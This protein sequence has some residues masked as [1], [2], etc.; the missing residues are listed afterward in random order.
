MSRLQSEKFF[1]DNEISGIK[2]T[3][4]EL[5]EKVKLGFALLHPDE[6]S[7]S[8]Q[9]KLYDD[10]VMDFTS[11]TKESIAKKRIIFEKFFVCDFRFEKQQNLHITLNRNN[12]P[13][14]FNTT[15]GN[16]IGSI[17]GTFTK[18]FD[19]DQCLV[20]KVEKLGKDE[21][22][23]NIRINLKN[24]T[25]PNFFLNNK[26]YYLITSRNN[27]IYKSAEITNFGFFAPIQIPTCLLQPSYTISFYN[28]YNKPIFTFNRTTQDVKTKKRLQLKIH[29][30][31]DKYLIL[32]DN[33]EITQKF[34]FLDYLKSGI[35]IALSIGI[36]FSTSHIL[37]SNY[38]TLHSIQGGNDYERAIISCANILGYYDYDQL[39]PVFGFGAIIN[40]SYSN[41]PSTCFNLNFAENP[42]IYTISNVLKAYRDCIQQNMLTFSGHSQFT[43]LIRKVI[44]RI[45]Q[46]DIFEYHILLILTDGLIDDLQQTIDILV[47]ASLLPLSV[48]IV[49]IGNGDFKNMEILDGDQIPLTSSSGKKRMRDLVQFVPFSKYQNN[50]EKLSMEVLAEIPRQIVEYY[51]FKN[52]NPNQIENLIKSGQ[53]I[54]NYN[55]QNNYQYNQNFNNTNSNMLNPGY[56]INPNEGSHLRRVYTNPVNINYQNPNLFSNMNNNPNIDSGFK[57]SFTQGNDIYYQEK[58]DKQD[59]QIININN[60][61]SYTNNIYINNSQKSDKMSK[62]VSSTSNSHNS[63]HNAPLD[64]PKK[65]VIDLTNIP[66]SETVTLTHINMKK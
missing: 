54:N 39:F 48:I 50:A 62:S 4:T 37:S 22:L 3:S 24:N 29:F 51:Q 60:N 43:P 15:L 26:L 45:N 34:T 8:I 12:N 21:D 17:N 42:D 10:Q 20:I 57:R 61:N 19:K 56:I 23:L 53:M 58:Q 14:E 27:D 1:N 38:D 65:E 40:S 16:V 11:E 33:S 32:E 5:Y 35:K 44:S 47:E 64:H 6:G 46:R 36:D 52:L 18:N 31:N 63:K 2:N 59:K 7:Y 9:A 55:Y 30:L 13:V 49:G 28:F 66:I 25:D 41:E